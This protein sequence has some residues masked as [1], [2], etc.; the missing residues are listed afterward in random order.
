MVDTLVTREPH[1]RRR[2]VALGGNHDKLADKVEK[3]AEGLLRKAAADLF[4]IPPFRSAATGLSLLGYATGTVRWDEEAWP[5]EPERGRGYKSRRETYEQSKKRVFPFI[6]EFP[7]PSRVL[8]PHTDREPSLAIETLTMPKWEVDKLLGKEERSDD[9]FEQVQVVNYWES[10]FEDWRAMYADGEEIEVVRNELGFIPWTHAFSGFGAERTTADYAS[11]ESPPGLSMGIKASDQAVGLFKGIED[12]ITFMDEMNSALRFVGMT[13]ANPVRF[14]TEDGQELA[15]QLAEAGVG[16][17]VE[18]TSLSNVK[19]ET[20]PPISNSLFQIMGN[21]A[22]DIDLGTFSGV[23]QG[24]RTPGVGTAT[25]HALMLGSARQRF[26]IPMSQLNYM[27]AQI[28]SFCARMVV[29]R[30]EP[31]TINGITCGPKDFEGFYDFEVNF[32][33]MDEGSALRD[34]QQSMAE[35]EKGLEDF[36]GFQRAKGVEDATGK[37][38]KI[39]IDKA[40]Q[41]EQ[42]MGPIIQ[43][44]VSAF[45]RKVEEEGGVAV[46]PPPPTQPPQPLVPGEPRG[47]AAQSEAAGM[48]QIPGRAINRVIPGV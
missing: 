24:E 43:A 40:L 35:Y 36:E 26:E 7:H 38:R 37:R 48:A 10:G 34:R 17:V 41:S 21:A 29:E 3:W 22:Q 23:V 13:A 14:T 32:M 31:V 33:A 27:A 16:G 25:Q 4:T 6:I 8:I 46:P 5:T 39:F 42:V 15:Q 18:L 2:P 19:W 47:I 12:S 9:P 44:A 1:V 45:Q 11:L 20:P 30:G 28:L